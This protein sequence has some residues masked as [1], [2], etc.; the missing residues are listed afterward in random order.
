MQGLL[1]SGHAGINALRL[2]RLFRAASDAPAWSVWR[3]VRMV[4]GRGGLEVARVLRWGPMS[5][6]V[7]VVG[8]VRDCTKCG[9]PVVLDA[10]RIAGSLYVCVSCK[11][12]ASKRWK[13]ANRDRHNANQRRWWQENP[14][15][16]QRYLRQWAAG[17]PEKKRAQGAL[18]HAV[19]SGR[20]ARGNCCVCLSPRVQGHHE[21]Y[22]K[23]LEVMWLCAQHHKD[24]H[25][26]LA[27]V[28]SV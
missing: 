24:R 10:R 8:D 1:Q 17:N 14:E 22:T 26:E 21:D 7:W 4:L 13:S 27:G 25:R 3:G 6:K 28:Q 16:T 11:T 2:S 15:K 9:V 23:P 12:T 5:K 20:I 18:Q 19:R